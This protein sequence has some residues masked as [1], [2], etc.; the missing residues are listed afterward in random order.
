M[1]PVLAVITP[2]YND[3]ASFRSVVADLDR[4]AATLNLRFRVYAVDDGSTDAIP[5][6]LF[7][8]G[9]AGH[10][11]SLTVVQLALNMG[12]QRALAIGLCTALEDPETAQIIVM[13]ADG[14]DRPS[15]IPA[16]LAAAKEAPGAVLVAK[17]AKRS[18]PLLFRIFYRIYKAL[19]RVLTGK[20]VNFGNF[21]LLSLEHAQRLSM[22]PELW[23]N[24]PAGIMRSRLRV[25]GVPIARGKRY[26]GS[27]KM[28]FVSLTLHGMSAY[29][30]YTDAILVRLLIGTIVFT[31]A[32]ALVSAI[33]ILLRLFTSHATP[34]WATTVVFGLGIIASQATFTTLMSALLLLNAR[35]QK[36]IVP[37]AEYRQYIRRRITVPLRAV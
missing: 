17:R 18:E 1:N 29:S 9:A 33:V 26:A 13:D 4:A 14:E 22:V 10:L 16:M 11:D 2:V 36:T 3:W 6:D 24:L 23:N 19:F 20:T 34:G 35:S 25:I 5:D 8:H 15:D 7:D 21:C 12:H 37:Q 32:S 27:S 28:S 31:A 30:V